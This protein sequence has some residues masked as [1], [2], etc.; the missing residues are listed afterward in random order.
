MHF[1]FIFDFVFDIICCE[2]SFESI[3]VVLEMADDPDQGGKRSLEEDGKHLEDEPDLATK[4]P[5]GP[6]DCLD[7]EDSEE[8]F[9]PFTQERPVDLFKEVVIAKKSAPKRS[10]AKG[11]SSTKPRRKDNRS[12]IKSSGK[13]KSKLSG[14]YFF[15]G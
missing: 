7:W 6:S 12:K 5:R 9:T 15:F 10:F 8:E 2:C 4:R 11:V 1:L 14:D 3:T 13:K